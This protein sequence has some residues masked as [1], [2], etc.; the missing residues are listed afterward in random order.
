MRAK[1]MT[2]ELP[3]ALYT[4]A[5]VR[6]FDRIAVEDF[7]IPGAHLMERAGGRAYHWMRS[8]WPRLRELLV[9]CGVGNNAGDGL[10]LARL[11]K[12][13]G[14]PVRVLQL[15]DPGRLQGDA[16]AMAKAWFEAGGVIEPYADLPGTAEL[17]V[18]AMLGTG[19]DREVSGAWA[20][21]IEEINRHPAPV[22]AL[23]IPSGLHA[24]SGR[25]MG[26]AIQASA[27]MSFIGL[28]QGMFTGQGPDCCGEI[29]FDALEIPAEI[30]ARQPISTQRIDWNRLCRRIAPRRRSAN[31]GDFGHL[32]AIGGG[33]G[34]PGA[35][36]LAAEAAARSGA[37]LVTLATHRDHAGLLSLGRP[38]L[39][40]RGVDGVDELV[41]LIQR[42]TSIVL[43]PGL[44]RDEWGERIYLAA[45]G[46]GLPQVLDADGLFW[47]SRHPMHRE[48]RILTPHPGEAA[49]LLQCSVADVQADR[50]AALRQLQARY[51]GV[52]VLKG[53]GTLIA[54]A[55]GR[56]PALCSG[57]NP[58]MA[59]GGSGD[60]LSG[61]IGALVA[62]GYALREAAELGVCLHAAA[63]DRAA[64]GGEI[65]LLAGD[66]LPEL[67]PL[68]NPGLADA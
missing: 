60:L 51:G 1:P 40:C 64:R 4:A 14:L 66:L 48:S 23:D 10:V 53:A 21:A 50:F 35:I 63:G 28:K 46:S 47:L 31:K 42:A 29:A 62:Q 3:Y 54:D 12:S 39:I 41:P 45:V 2:G 34:Y 22:F 37:G 26:A 32:L 15:G 38:E 33:P 18:D 55:S 25:V 5:Q 9:V 49:R 13:A 16:Q 68:L 43:G 30:Y 36:R 19:L 65:G 57:G 24:D 11:A 17:I 61:I 7:G 58:G 59:S 20:V 27:S 56:P 67:R 44:G 52:V 6:E 8:R